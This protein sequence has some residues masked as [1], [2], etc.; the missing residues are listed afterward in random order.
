[1]SA[2]RLYSVPPSVS[3]PTQTRD[4]R[5]AMSG[6]GAAQPKRSSA[7]RRR[8]ERA[9]VGRRVALRQRWPVPP[10]RRRRPHEAV[11]GAGQTPLSHLRTR[12]VTGP[13][14]PD[15]RRGASAL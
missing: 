5:L 2:D 7:G 13:I 1:M 10:R 11:G 14:K 12:S 6:A 8:R 15:G 4:M 3:P 9:A